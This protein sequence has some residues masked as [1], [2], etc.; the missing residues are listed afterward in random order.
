MNQDIKKDSKEKTV[1]ETANKLGATFA[2][3]LL[4]GSPFAIA[5]YFS[6]KFFPEHLPTFDFWDYGLVIIFAWSVKHIFS[7]KKKQEE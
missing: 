7:K 4:I 3:M 6:T 5:L 1:D 2:K